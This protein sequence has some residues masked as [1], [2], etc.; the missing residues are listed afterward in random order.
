MSEAVRSLEHLQGVVRESKGSG[1]E[2]RPAVVK[3]VPAD[4]RP[5]EPM[6]LALLPEEAEALRRAHDDLLNDLRFE[7]MERS[8]EKELWRF[9]C[10]A[11]LDPKNDFVGRF[12]DTHARQPKELICYIPVEFLKVTSPV[13]VFGMQLLPLGDSRI[14]PARW[15]F[16]LDAPVASVLAIPVMGTNHGRMADRAENV[17]RHAL[18][19]LRIG[20][21][22]HMGITN[23]QLRFR[24]GEAYSFDEGASGSQ[25]AADTAYELEINQELVQLAEDQPVAQVP[26]EPRTDVDEKAAIAARWMERA[27][28]AT[29]PLVALLYLFFALEALLG[30]KS[31]GLK[32]HGLAFRQAILS[33][34][35]TGHFTHPNETYFLYDRVRSGAVHGEDAPDVNWDTV[36]SFA[37]TVRWTLSHYLTFTRAN[38]ITRRGRLLKAL[39][40]HPERPKLT[41]WLTA[42]GGPHWQTYFSEP[43][44]SGT[45]RTETAGTE[46]GRTSADPA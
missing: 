46:Q 4:L 14:P 35:V 15:R 32:A 39:R 38:G 16:K 36:N 19:L 1:G 27:W 24:L 30:D 22:E 18:R 33:A 12:V 3:E 45:N 21:R 41:E 8:L 44:D 2:S 31:E 43:G 42:V 13:H 25:A 34:A 17:A 7:H 5:G 23:R 37:T 29:E 28:F 11:Y 6:E 26:L 40:E 20:L 9:V 10:K